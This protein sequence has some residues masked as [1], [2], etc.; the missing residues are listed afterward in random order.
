M[1]TLMFCLFLV[2]F[3]LVKGQIGS[4]K[5]MKM[6]AIILGTRIECTSID[7]KA[8][9]SL[10]SKIPIN[11]KNYVGLRGHFNWWD[12]PGRKF[13]VIPELDYFRKIASFEENK[14][15][16][17]GLYAGAGITPNA[18]SPKFGVNLYYFLTAELGYNYEFTPYKHFST[19][20]F[21][22]SFGINIVY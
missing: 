8:F 12:L 5:E 11:E 14:P 10:G 7:S 6:L 1:K 21:R 13:I 9:L 4:E 18:V 17:T 20:G 15:I 22:F 2:V 16:V 3:P 19:E